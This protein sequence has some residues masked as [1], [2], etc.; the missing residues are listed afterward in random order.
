MELQQ[1][2]STIELYSPSIDMSSSCQAGLQR[3]PLWLA[4]HYIAW[5]VKF[6]AKISCSSRRRKL[7]GV[8][9][10]VRIAASN[11]LWSASQKAGRCFSMRS[12]MA[13]P[14]LWQR[15]NGSPVATMLVGWP[16]HQRI[17]AAYSLVVII[18]ARYTIFVRYPVGSILL[19]PTQHCV[20]QRSF[21]LVVLRSG[22]ALTLRWSPRQPL[23]RLVR[24]PSPL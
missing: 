17:E 22:T 5:L 13:W 18:L 7:S 8:G 3:Q 12:V 1:Q 16:Y 24:A 14:Y 6:F 20:I 23:P 10:V 2:C 19:F 15:L 4:G 9:K 21:L 11:S